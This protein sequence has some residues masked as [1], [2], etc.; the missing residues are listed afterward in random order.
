MSDL[1]RD[2]IA[3]SLCKNPLDR[4]TVHEMLQHP[5]V[6]MFQRRKSVRVACHRSNSMMELATLM[7]NT[8]I[9]GAAHS[10]G[11]PSAGSAGCGGSSQQAAGA[12]AGGGVAAGGA[13]YSA[14]SS[15]VVSHGSG[16]ALPAIVAM[17]GGA[18]W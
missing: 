8:G 12:A 7:C 6:V 9:G 13:F 1:A 2:F 3:T 15:P 16:S 5:W 17:S 11:G 10:A 4:P 14:P 18:R